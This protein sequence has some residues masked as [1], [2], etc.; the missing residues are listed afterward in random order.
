MEQAAPALEGASLALKEW[1]GVQGRESLPPAPPP[2][3]REWMR[4]HS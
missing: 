2:A 3:V 1:L 4:S